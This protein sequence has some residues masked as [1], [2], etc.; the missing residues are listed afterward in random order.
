ML[1]SL[2]NQFLKVKIVINKLRFGWIGE[3]YVVW[4]KVRFKV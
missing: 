1:R 3:G 2:P 4:G